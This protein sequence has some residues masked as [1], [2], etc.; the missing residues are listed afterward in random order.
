[1][2]I[3]SRKLFC[4]APG[5]SLSQILPALST[6]LPEDFLF[7]NVY[8][9]SWYNHLDGDFH[10]I[11]IFLTPVITRILFSPSSVSR[12]SILSTLPRKCPALKRFTTGGRIVPPSAC[13]FLTHTSSPCTY[14][15]TI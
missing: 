15:G 3:D 5:L 9:L 4:E 8:D 1:M 12:F 6:S 2:L 10:Y 14:L 7:P 13:I 11:D